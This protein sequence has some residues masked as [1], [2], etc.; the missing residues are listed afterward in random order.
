[1]AT[2]FIFA[3][4]IEFTINTTGGMCLFLDVHSYI[5]KVSIL[6]SLNIKQIDKLIIQDALNIGFII[7]SIIILEGVKFKIK[8]LKLKLTEYEE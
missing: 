7:I 6:N 1:M 5:C 3:G 4:F 2:H 8:I